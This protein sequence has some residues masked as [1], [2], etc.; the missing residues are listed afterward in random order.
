MKIKSVEDR[1]NGE[2][3]EENDW[4]II[5]QRGEEKEKGEGEYLV[6]KEEED[7]KRKRVFALCNTTNF[8]EKMQSRQ[9]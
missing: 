3:K 8:Y 9:V 1:N 2:G 7:P 6:S 4:R 5:F